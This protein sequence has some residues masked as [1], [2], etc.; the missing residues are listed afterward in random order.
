M[1][2]VQN[3]MFTDLPTV[4]QNTFQAGLNEGANGQFLP[5]QITMA[6]RSRVA[7]PIYLRLQKNNSPFLATKSAVLST[8][9][10]GVVQE[11]N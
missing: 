1:S 11:D 5:N 7:T 9:S 4:S 6:T 3:P 8:M 10:A 2:Y